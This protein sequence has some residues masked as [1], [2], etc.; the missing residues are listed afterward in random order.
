M[1]ALARILLQ[2]KMNE[3]MKKNLAQFR[4]FTSSSSSFLNNSDDSN[5]N[6]CGHFMVCAFNF[7]ADGWIG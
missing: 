1:F 2:M 5:V 7:A 3:S 4:F 6:A